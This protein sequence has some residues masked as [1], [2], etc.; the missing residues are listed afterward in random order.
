MTWQRL[1]PDQNKNSCQ[2]RQHAS[3]NSDAES[4]EGDDPHRD[5]INRE[6]KHADIFSNHGVSMRNYANG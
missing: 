4:S 6:Q 5:E 1:T 2:Q 3:Y